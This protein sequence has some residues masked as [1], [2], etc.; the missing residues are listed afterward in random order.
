[1]YTKAISSVLLGVQACLV[2][3]EADVSK[4]IPYFAMTGVLSTEVREAG[5]RI[6]TAIRNVGYALSSVRVIINIAP[7]GVRKAGTNL[8]LPMALA[9]LAG[10]GHV[11]RERLEEF[12]IMGELGL[13]GSI[14]PIS[15]VLPAVIKARE[16]GI[17]SCIVPAGNYAE[18]NIITNMKVHPAENL[19]DALYVISHGVSPTIMGK[20]KTC[21]TGKITINRTDFSDIKG[22]YAAKRATMIAAAGRHNLLYIGPPGSGKSMLAERTPGI[23][24]PISEEESI[25]I[26]GIYSAAGLLGPNGGLM[27]ERPFRNPHHTISKA[28]LL[29]GGRYPRPG[30]IT[31]SHGGVLFLDE[32]PLFSSEVIEGLRIPLEQKKLK[33]VRNGQALEFPADFVLFAA[34]NPCKCGYFPDRNHCCCTELEISRYMGKISRPL[35]DRFDM[36]I[37]V[38][39]PRYEQLTKNTMENL[40]TAT[41]REAVLRAADIQKERYKGT[42]IHSNADLSARN[43]KKYCKI[44]DAGEDFLKNIYDSCHMSARGYHKLL[45]TARTIADLEGREEITMAHLSE[46]VAY[47]S[48]DARQEGEN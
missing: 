4:G 7:A 37:R 22:Q 39:R 27:E 21:S 33:I 19:K 25:E 12:L 20:K 18:A 16:K 41:M 46:A 1:M 30:E 40:D 32:L 42:K 3:V 34:M 2:R 43:V 11:P 10:M 29:G 35:L 5:E 44:D 13:D 47:R 23:L 17:T 38:D 24:P 14:N 9:I 45:K 6:R 28:G 8:D 48:I 15:G 36:T 31:L 26:S